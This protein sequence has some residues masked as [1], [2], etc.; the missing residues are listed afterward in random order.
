M[1]KIPP[2]RKGQKLTAESLEALRLAVEQSRITVAPPL[3]ATEGPHGTALR[4]TLPEEIW[5]RITG[6]GTLGK[7]AWVEQSPVVGGLWRDGFR[8]GTETENYALESNANEGVPDE[9]IVRLLRSHS[10]NV[11]LFTYSLCTA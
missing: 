1:I 3:E 5:G 4:V 11:W 7:Y 6:G 10:S 9:A 8:M 2:F